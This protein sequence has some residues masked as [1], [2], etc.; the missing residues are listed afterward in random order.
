MN[1]GVLKYSKSACIMDPDR[2][3]ILDCE[4]KK[5][6]VLSPYGSGK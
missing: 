4:G 3:N 5:S 6:D 1:V 2:F